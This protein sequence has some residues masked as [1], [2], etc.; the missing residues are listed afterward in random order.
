MQKCFYRKDHGHIF[1]VAY[2][3]KMK[4]KHLLFSKRLS[5]YSLHLK[6]IHNSASLTFILR[7]PQNSLKKKLSNDLRI[8]ACNHI[9][10]VCTPFLSCHGLPSV[11]QIILYHWSPWQAVILVP[12]GTKVGSEIFQ[13]FELHWWWMV[14]KLLYSN[15][16]QIAHLTFLW[17]GQHLRL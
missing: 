2:A 11:V 17:K 16:A 15:Q 14:E 6:R 3:V 10:S 7:F 1:A 9:L 4:I 13:S 12:V 5:F 8:I